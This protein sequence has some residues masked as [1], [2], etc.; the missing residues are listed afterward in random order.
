MGDTQQVNASSANYRPCCLIQLARTLPS[1]D[2][3]TSDFFTDGSVCRTRVSWI[4]QK[5]LQEMLVKSL[6]SDCIRACC[7]Y[8]QVSWSVMP[9]YRQQDITGCKIR[10]R[11]YCRQ[12]MPCAAFL[13]LRKVWC[14]WQVGVC[15]NYFWTFF[16]ER[17]ASSQGVV[18]VLARLLLKSM[19]ALA[20]HW[21]WQPGPG[22]SLKRY[23]LLAV[24]TLAC[25][26]SIMFAVMC[27]THT[28]SMRWDILECH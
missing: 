7:A 2:H 28:H 4:K 26:C 16:L 19:P 22:T 14:W 17:F 18:A 9:M 24:N 11:S 1:I 8:T 13:R 23:G 21:F 3:C 25:E 10:N 27:A 5:K 12:G 20:S 6:C 15:R